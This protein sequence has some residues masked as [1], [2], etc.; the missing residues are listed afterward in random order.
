MKVTSTGSLDFARDDR[1]REQRQHAARA[2][3][4]G[5]IRI[6]VLEIARGADA[7]V[8]N[9][10]DTSR[11]T[12]RHDLRRKIDFVMRRANAW[13]ELHDE[14]GSFHTEAIVQQLDGVSGDSERASFLAGV[15]KANGAAMSIGEINGT[16]ISDINPETDIRLI[17]DEAVAILEAVVARQ[18][19]LDDSDLISVNLPRGSKGVAFEAEL[20][21]RATMHLVEIRQHHRFVV[22]QLD[23]GNTPHKTV[24]QLHLM[25]RPE[26]ID[27]Q[28]ATFQPIGRAC[29]ASRSS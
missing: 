24:R 11:A 15:H 12:L 4:L 2:T 23:A 20:A 19:R 6:V 21:P 5:P 16:A 18:R 14:V 26:P 25:E 7:A 28:L 8:V 13:A 29:A 9:F 17:C 3:F 1:K 22:R 10:T 27:G